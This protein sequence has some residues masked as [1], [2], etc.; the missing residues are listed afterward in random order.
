MGTFAF[1][2]LKVQHVVARTA[3]SRVPAAALLLCTQIGAQA[4]AVVESLARR[5]AASGGAALLI[6]YGAN[7]PYT[8]SLTGGGGHECSL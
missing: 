4:M 2:Q 6:D 3:E 5:I 1:S 8:N 7:K